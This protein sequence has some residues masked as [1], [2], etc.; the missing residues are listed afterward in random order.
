MSDLD[1]NLDGK[2]TKDEQ[3]IVDTRDANGGDVIDYTI[4]TPWKYN[5]S[6]GYTIGSNLALGA[7]YD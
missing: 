3:F 7:E 4:V 5:V 2:V 1:L 6:L